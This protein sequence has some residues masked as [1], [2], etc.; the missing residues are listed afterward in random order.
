TPMMHLS[1]AALYAS[2]A[3]VGP[4]LPPTP[5]TRISPSM[6]AKSAASAL[7]GS[8]RNTSRSSGPAKRPGNGVS[9]SQG[10]MRGPRKRALF[11]GLPRRRAHRLKPVGRTRRYHGA[12]HV[13]RLAH[14]PRPAAMHGRA[15]VPHHHV[16]LVPGVHVAASRRGRSG[17]QFA[18][19]LF[20]LHVAHALD[21]IGVRRD[22]EG[23]TAVDWI[24][25][26]QAPA[27]R[28]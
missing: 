13:A 24:F 10:V 9:S 1:G 7:P 23:V 8:V 15:I 11:R 26:H 18:E 6:A 28:R 4:I 20:T 2:R 17:H 25:P 3:S 27:L 12:H 21:R 19:Q 16:A 5:S 22:V 14:R